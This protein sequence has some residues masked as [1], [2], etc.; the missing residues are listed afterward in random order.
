MGYFWWGDTEADLHHK[1]FFTSPE[2]LI[3]A[4]PEGEPGW[5]AIVGRV[6]EPDSIWIWDVDG[7]AWIDTG[8]DGGVI[9]VNGKTGAVSLHLGNILPG[10]VYLRGDDDTDGSV[11]VVSPSENTLHVQ[12]RRDGIWEDDLKLGYDSILRARQFCAHPEEAVEGYRLHV[13]GADRAVLTLA[14]DGALHLGSSAWGEIVIPAKT[15][16][17]GTCQIGSAFPV[18]SPSQYPPSGGSQTR[19]AVFHDNGANGNT[20]AFQ[21][22]MES[23]GNEGRK[24]AVYGQ[25]RRTTHYGGGGMLLAGVWGAVHNL[26]NV[27]MRQVG[28]MATDAP[29]TQPEGNASYGL[30][31]S[32]VQ[33]VVTSVTNIAVYAQAAIAAVG[34]KAFAGWFKGDVVVE[35]QS[36]QHRTVQIAG[37]GSNN[38][39]RLQWNGSV[40]GN[41]RLEILAGHPTNSRIVSQQGRAFQISGGGGVGVSYSSTGENVNV[42]V[43][44]NVNTDVVLRADAVPTQEANLFEAAVNK[45]VQASI[46]REGDIYAAGNVGINLVGSSTSAP[47]EFSFLNTGSGRACRFLYFG[48]AN[49]VQT[50]W[51]RCLQMYS[52]NTIELRGGKGTSGA[53][54]Y[55][56]DKNV[57]VDIVNEQDKVALRILG[58]PSQFTPLQQ[59]CDAGG[60]AQAYMDS[61]GGFHGP[62]ALLGRVGSHPMSTLW[63]DGFSVFDNWSGVQIQEFG[64]SNPERDMLR[65]Q[66]SGEGS[67]SRIGT[68]KHA[69]L[70]ANREWVLPDKGGTLALAEDVGASTPDTVLVDGELI[71]VVRLTA[72]EA[73]AAGWAWT[74]NGD[75][76]G[77]YWMRIDE[78]PALSEPT[79]VRIPDYIDGVP[80]ETTKNLLS[81]S[82]ELWQSEA[83]KENLIGITG[84][85]IRVLGSRNFTACENMVK[86]I[87]P[88]LED[89]GSYVFHTCSALEEINFPR[90]W[91][92]GMNNFTNCSSLTHVE[93]P[94]LSEVRDYVFGGCTALKTLTLPKLT[95]TNLPYAMFWNCPA[96]EWLRIGA[97]FGIGQRLTFGGTTNPDLLVYYNPGETGFGDVWPASGGDHGRP[98]APDF[99]KWMKHSG[100]PAVGEV[101]V[102]VAGNTYAWG[103]P[104]A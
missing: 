18:T 84:L 87:M 41:T 29:T 83:N 85:N 20:A 21:S 78:A 68:L 91:R 23:N 99:Q 80:V 45:E 75:G 67:E 57:G 55:V 9:S 100:N 69:P 22:F 16:I 102:R 38:L 7:A 12:T 32:A 17:Q 71:E 40:D 49:G 53:P 52:Y 64:S 8:I 61:Q 33:T 34:Q 81:G 24:I 15:M 59:W 95:G 66:S 50:G 3:A 4:H 43:T 10:M 44:N 82:T 76:Q 14:A 36:G 25:G 51:D 97:Y 65:I 79:H 56:T 72:E 58:A 27:A 101:P 93:L 47:R 88:K 60:L 94:N 48:A 73:T 35:A 31:A 37:V 6:G 30:F 26:K 90:L 11:R 1:G 89:C 46:S 2:A 70:S 74:W 13:D 54:D 104:W 28:V 96:L 39:G 42:A 77:H 92:V 86:C 19:L 5:F 98:C 63:I 103:T 62:S